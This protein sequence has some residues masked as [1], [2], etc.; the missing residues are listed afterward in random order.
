[1]SHGIA[2]NEADQFLY[3]EA[4]T[5]PQAWHREGL[6]E[7][8]SC[9]SELLRYAR[10]Q[11]I[12][13]VYHWHM[14][15]CNA[16]GGYKGTGRLYGATDG[17]YVATGVAEAWISYEDGRELFCGDV[18]KDHANAMEASQ[19]IEDFESLLWAAQN[20]GGTP[21]NMF[22]L[23]DGTRIVATYKVLITDEG[24]DDEIVHY[25]VL[26]EDLT[27][28]KARTIM[29]QSIRTV[30]ANTLHAAELTCAKGKRIK[31]RHSG[32][33]AG[34]TRIAAAI[35]SRCQEVAGEIGEFYK[36]AKSA[37]ITTYEEFDHVVR[38]FV[39]DA[40]DDDGKVLT[41]GNKYNRVD[42]ARNALKDAARRKENYCG[43]TVATYFNAATYL[44]DRNADGS[45]AE[46]KGG[47]CMIE[48][49]L[50]GDRNHKLNGRSGKNPKAGI[51]DTTQELVQF[52][53]QMADGTTE[54]MT[55]AQAVETGQVPTSQL[56]SSIMEGMDVTE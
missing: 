45:Q 31:I 53:V 17:P 19:P 33:L 38:A 30:C 20:G 23:K 26:V 50:F 28:S 51:L 4:D 40:L 3:V 39:P 54:A 21:S 44:L 22:A 27:G 49:M 48:S 32:D 37:K 36:L 6:R 42:K 14:Q 55:L 7:A 11:G 10:T 34:K 13:P 5:E 2:T 46:A 25:L 16:K 41:E 29:C 9:T 56:G 12:M 18:G 43:S 15:A 8:I 35:V 52:L 24:T 47:S 1:M